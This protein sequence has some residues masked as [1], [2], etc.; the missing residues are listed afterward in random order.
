MR[1]QL[2]IALIS[3][4][5]IAAL[6]TAGAVALTT[7]QYFGTRR[8]ANILSGER[9]AL[10]IDEL[11]VAAI[12]VLRE[13]TKKGRF[14]AESETWANTEFSATH[15]DVTAH[16]QLSDLQA[17]FNLTNLSPDPI[18]QNIAEAA[19]PS[20]T[21]SPPALA[22]A[23]PPGTV[24][25]EPGAECAEPTPTTPNVAALEATVAAIQPTLSKAAERRL[26]LL[27]KAL[28]L[29]ETPVQAILDWIDPDTETR[30]PNG[31]EDDYYTEQWPAYRTANRPLASS[32]E[33]LLV[34]GITMEAFAK[35]APLVI[36]L[37][38]VTK[39]NVNTAPKEVLMSL[40]PG[41]DS[42][43]AAAIIRARQAQPFLSVEMF[44]QHPLLQ[45]RPIRAHTVAIGSDYFALDSDA[46]NQRFEISMQSTLKRSGGE[47]T[48]IARQRHNFDE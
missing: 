12:R 6:V 28:N 15:G 4:M 14:D 37:P 25:C 24:A 21:D 45:F 1:G 38:N 23:A 11:E 40:A 20:S 44:L 10:A 42:G 2:G 16:G 48:V 30:F 26:R 3:A 8:V 19:A 7:Q 13:D 27:F 39:I 31:A 35:L 29:D 5:L 34:K 18:V 36:C 17:K 22:T 46:D 43:A 32:R 47:V 41:I 33:L 9:A